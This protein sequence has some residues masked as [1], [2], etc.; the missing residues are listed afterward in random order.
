MKAPPRLTRGPGIRAGSDKAD[1]AG[2]ERRTPRLMALLLRNWP[3]KLGALLLSI[4]L[5]A[6][7]VYSGSFTE[8]EIAGVPIRATNQPLNTYLLTG[9]LGTVDVSYRASAG[10]A[11]EVTISTFDVTVDLEAYDLTRAGRAAAAAGRGPLPG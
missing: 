5:Y 10:A 8:Q 9:E 3:L 6:G 1:R 7:L 2:G 11:G 4:L